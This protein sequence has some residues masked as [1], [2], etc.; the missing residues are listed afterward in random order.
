MVTG[1]R[2]VADWE[3]WAPFG[4]GVYYV[5]PHDSGEVTIDFFDCVSHKSRVILTMRHSPPTESGG[6]ALSPDG[7]T[8]L[9]TEVDQD[10]RN[11][12]AQ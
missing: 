4:Q 6:M 7:K 5:H 11:I 9:F 10:D 3:N 12:F 8:L 1:L 2:S